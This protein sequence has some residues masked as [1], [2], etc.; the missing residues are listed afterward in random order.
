MTVYNEVISQAKVLLEQAEKYATKPT[1]AESK[2]LRAT[3]G[4]IQKKA[5]QAKKDLIAADKGE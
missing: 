3:I 2:R 5:V 1:K 4:S